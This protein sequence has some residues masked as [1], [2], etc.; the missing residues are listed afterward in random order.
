[1]I[2]QIKQLMTSLAQGKDEAAKKEFTSIM[3]AKR[4]EAIDL[5]KVAVAKSVYGK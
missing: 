2:T 5:K 4:E 3:A 1:M